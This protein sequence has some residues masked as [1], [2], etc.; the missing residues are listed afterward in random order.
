MSPRLPQVAP[1]QLRRNARAAAKLLRALGN[2]SR[3]MLLC[4]LTEGDRTVGELNAE[5]VT[6]WPREG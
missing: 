4:A 3:L 6:L 2:E 1:A 5:G